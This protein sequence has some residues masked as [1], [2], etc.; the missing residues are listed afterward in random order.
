[1]PARRPRPLA[2]LAPLVALVSAQVWVAEARADDRALATELF[3]AGRDRMAAGDF[4]GACPKL[5]ESVRLDATVGAL[6]KLAACEEQQKKL[7]QAYGHWEQAL[8][9][10]RTLGDDRLADVAAGLAR[11]GQRVPKLL[12]TASPA[13]PKDLSLRLDDLALGPGSLGVPLPIEP[14]HHQVIVSA[15]GLSPWSTAFDA[16]SDGSTTSLTV[17]ALEPL[18]LP[19]PSTAPSAT[20]S[21]S[22]P[23]GPPLP[24]APARVP[25]SRVTLPTA[26]LVTAGVGLAALVTGTALAID[27]ASQQ[28]A[29]HCQGTV[30]P[31]AGSAATLGNA[32]S[33]ADGATVAF[34]TG[35]ALAVG[36]VVLWLLLPPTPARGAWLELGPARG[37]LTLRWN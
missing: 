32:R 19:P 26:A 15:A 21:T 35:G 2:L 1:M 9:L 6:A 18:P 20:P 5:A 16:A 24:P 7:V 30:C 34:A 31:D 37:G 4:E 3:N 27:A 23:L 14:G 10:A 13:A 28:S 11:L 22:P 12:V 36:A 33:E 17:P 8:N 29:A 25:P